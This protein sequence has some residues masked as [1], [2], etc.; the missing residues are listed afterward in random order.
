M[1]D[2]KFL[3]TC[4]PWACGCQYLDLDADK[5]EGMTAMLHRSSD[6]AA[7]LGSSMAA[8]GGSG[9]FGMMAVALT[10]FGVVVGM[11][12]YRA[13]KR[14]GSSSTYESLA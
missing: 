10:V 12:S 3:G 13:G 9:S 1:Y 2:E 5:F 14:S 11:V 7:S 6:L 4:V 8:T